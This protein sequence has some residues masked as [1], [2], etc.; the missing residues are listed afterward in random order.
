[1]TCVQDLPGFV[2]DLPVSVQLFSGKCPEI[3]RIEPDRFRSGR[4]QGAGLS[5]RDLRHV[6]VLYPVGGSGLGDR[7]VQPLPDR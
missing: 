3:N 6:S 7:T 5:D 1:M 2:Q 4:V